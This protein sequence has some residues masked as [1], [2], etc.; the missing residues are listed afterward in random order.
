MQL[1]GVRADEMMAHGYIITQ[2]HEKQKGFFLLFS[3]TV[4]PQCGDDMI[5]EKRDYRRSS[6]R[7]SRGREAERDCCALSVLLHAE[8]RKYG[9]INKVI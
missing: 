7:E 2:R 1:A 3:K 8:D 6:E 4:V 5:N 9:K